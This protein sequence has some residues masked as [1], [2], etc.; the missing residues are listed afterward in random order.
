MDPSISADT[1]VH[2]LLD[3]R[4]VERELLDGI[5]DG[6][7][8]GQPGHFLEPP[9][10]EIGHV[11]WFQEYWILRHLDDD[12]TLLRGSDTIYESFKVPYRLRWQHPYPS[13]AGTLDYIEH[14]LR[15]SSPASI[16]AGRTRRTR[17]STR[18]PRCTRTC[19]R[20]T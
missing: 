12:A 9:I 7:L 18:S 10:W 15:R 11:G 4:L 3:A 1:L 8:L 20:K 14:V 13:R 17:T 5:A 6:Q 2:T 19:T 16:R